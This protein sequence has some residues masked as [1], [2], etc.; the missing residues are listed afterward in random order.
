MLRAID[1]VSL[2]VLDDEAVRGLAAVHPSVALALEGGAASAAVPAGGTRLSRLTIAPGSR[3]S[4]VMPGVGGASGAPSADD[5]RR[6]TGSM[7]SVKR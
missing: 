4:I 3:L 6:L 5:V 2:L 1:A 7:P